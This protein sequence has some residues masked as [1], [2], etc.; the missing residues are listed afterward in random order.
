MRNDYLYKTLAEQLSKE[1]DASARDVGSPHGI[2]KMTAT[3]GKVFVRTS[4]DD[5]HN[6]WYDVDHQGNGTTLSEWAWPYD[7]IVK[8]DDL[9]PQD[10]IHKVEN[11]IVLSEAGHGHKFNMR[12]MQ[13][14]DRGRKV[15]EDPLLDEDVNPDNVDKDALPPK[16][17]KS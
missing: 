2:L 5:G 11:W 1:A 7:G 14:A 6:H 10:H 13:E 16:E 17:E 9:G 12:G 4:D 8:D 15:I 3:N